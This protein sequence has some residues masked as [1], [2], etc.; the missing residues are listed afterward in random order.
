MKQDATRYVRFKDNCEV[1]EYHN[2]NH[3]SNIW[4]GLI[5]VVLLLQ[6]IVVLSAGVT[7]V[8][9][10]NSNQ[11]KVQAWINLP[12]GDMA[13][14]VDDG[15]AGLKAAPISGTF[16]NAYKSAAKLRSMLEFHDRTTMRK[17]QIVVDEL[18]KNKDAISQI[19]NITHETLP[20]LKKINKVL[21][22]QPVK[23]ITGVIHKANAFMDFV[24]Q[25]SKEGNKNYQ[26]VTGIA[27]NIN[28]LVS[29]HNVERT[30]ASIEKISKVMDSTLTTYNVNKT[31]DALS[32]F[33]SSIH[34][35][36]NR[37]ALIG[38]ILG[39]N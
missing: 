39:K 30:I 25:D 10:Y 7:T 26:R 3:C 36:E 18:M 14:S 19:A 12:W 5:F 24:S 21:A 15:Y 8:L 2:N 28:H 20:A 34:K 32:D 6:A 16:N 22:D 13:Q 38:Q 33:D 29:P 9:I 23:D 11:E 31:I 35:A 27:D 37:M 4:L 17:V 1:L